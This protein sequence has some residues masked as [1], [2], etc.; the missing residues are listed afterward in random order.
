[1]DPQNLTCT[2]CKQITTDKGKT[3]WVCENCGAE[4]SASAI[5]QPAD[6]DVDV[7]AAQ[8]QAD[9]A[10]AAAQAGAPLDTPVQMP[11]ETPPAENQPTP[12]QQD[13]V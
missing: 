1:M 7:T 9:I 6:Q 4:N 13:P 5:N 2:N 8:A 11:A 3:V 10:A 12:I